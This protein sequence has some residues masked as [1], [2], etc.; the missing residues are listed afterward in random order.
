[1]Q[2]NHADNEKREKV[3]PEGVM[4]YALH[5]QNTCRHDRHRYGGTVAYVMNHTTPAQ[6]R[7]AIHRTASRM[8]AALDHMADTV[9][10]TMM[11]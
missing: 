9:C 1:M 10:R 5:K 3:L 2:T 4:N 8:S 7:R 11:G 6:R